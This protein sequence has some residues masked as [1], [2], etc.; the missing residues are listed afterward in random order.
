MSSF[1]INKSRKDLFTLC[2]N[3]SCCWLLRSAWIRPNNVNWRQHRFRSNRNS[4]LYDCRCRQHRF[5]FRFYRNLLL[6]SKFWSFFRF[7]LIKFILYEILSIHFYHILLAPQ[8]EMSPTWSVQIFSKQWSTTTY[9][10]PPSQT[11]LL[12]LRDC[13]KSTDIIPFST[14]LTDP[15]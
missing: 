14:T 7:S 12:D 10:T 9:V 4:D 2:S 15:Y 11:T 13:M 3:N 5:R 6:S 8:F 1:I